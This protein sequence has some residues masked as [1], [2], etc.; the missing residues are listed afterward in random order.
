MS[1][2]QFRFS[3]HKTD[4]CFTSA[5]ATQIDSARKRRV[6]S[7]TEPMQLIFCVISELGVSKRKFRGMQNSFSIFEVSS[8]FFQSFLTSSD[9]ASSQSTP[10]AATFCKINFPPEA[11]APLYPKGQIDSQADSPSRVSYLPRQT[12]GHLSSVC[13]FLGPRKGK[14]L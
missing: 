1:E 4:L 12:C 13:H 10:D 5:N 7:I 6:R 2:N 11:A 8:H 9:T 3:N 14:T